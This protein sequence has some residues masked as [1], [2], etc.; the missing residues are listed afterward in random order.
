MATNRSAM[1]IINDMD[2][3]D[4]TSYGDE[5]LDVG[6][7][8]DEGDDVQSSDTGDTGDVPTDDDNQSLGTEQGAG[9]DG[10]QQPTNV[11]QEQTQLTPLRGGM[12][13]DQNGNI[14]DPRTGQVL[15]RA[16]SERRMFERGVRQAAELD[17]V[18]TELNTTRQNLERVQYL[19]ELPRKLQLGTEEVEAGLGIV[20][21][22]KKNPVEAARKVVELAVSM[23]HNVSDILGKSA[24]DAIEMKAL[25]RMIDEKLA[26]VLAPIQQQRQTTEATRQAQRQLNEFV[27]Q[28]EYAD[29]HLPAIDKLIG[30]NPRL[31]PQQA[32]YEMRS[33]AQKYGLDFSRPLQP[34]IAAVQRQMQGERGQ[35]QQRP[36][37]YGQAPRQPARP[38]PN[39]S[40]GQAARSTADTDF[41]PASSDWADIIRGSMGSQR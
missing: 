37:Q 18:S 20:A 6:L 24:G 35:G 40:S 39:G 17:R 30:A 26:P 15:A 12:F 25:T 13:A 9:Q 3:A 4:G 29:V 7:Q 34:Q 38:M 19:N 10:T 8:N 16:G 36:V 14:V 27:D 32:Y 21:E 5:D 31:S 2:E 22:F 1:D 33:F 41:A 11:A 23:G 28:H